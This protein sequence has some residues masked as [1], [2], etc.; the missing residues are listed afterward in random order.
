MWI[1]PVQVAGTS[2]VRAEWRIE[3][4][5]ARLQACMGRPLVSP[6]FAICGLPNLRLMV[7]PDAREAVK[8]VRSR[9][10]K[11]LYA[12]MVKKGPL[13][14][15]LK[16]KADCLPLPTV[17]SFN[18]TVGGTRLGPFTYDFSEQAIHGCE[19]FNVD[20]LR[21][22]DDGTDNL[23]VGVEILEIREN[24]GLNSTVREGLSPQELYSQA[25]RQLYKCFGLRHVSQRHQL[26]D[27]TSKAVLL[28]RQRAIE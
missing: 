6:P 16:L 5:R 20:W 10:R 4:L 11:G 13:H 12:A 1:G 21:Q 25:L 7:F 18:L 17:L 2:S 8:S 19:D 26:L 14:G 27:P 24:R 23:R 3:D 15:G 9:E 22:V 28:P